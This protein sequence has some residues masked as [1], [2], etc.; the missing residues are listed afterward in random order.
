MLEAPDVAASDDDAADGRAGIISGARPNRV[1]FIGFP[2][3][4]PDG[5]TAHLSASID[6]LDGDVQSAIEIVR[7]NGGLFVPGSAGSEFQYF[8]PW[9]CALVRVGPLP[10]DHNAGEPD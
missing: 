10:V 7:R 8:L 4:L 2:C 1:T 3:T 6:V 9:P 5:T